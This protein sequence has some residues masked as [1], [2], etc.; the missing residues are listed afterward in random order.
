MQSNRFDAIAAEL[1]RLAA[2]IVTLNAQPFDPE[3]EL[4]AAGEGSASFF[5]PSGNNQVSSIV[6]DL[7]RSG[8]TGS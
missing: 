6:A 8:T 3:L 7:T 2:E 1:N 4:R 5:E